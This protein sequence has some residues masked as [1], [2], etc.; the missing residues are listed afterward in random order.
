MLLK[1]DEIRKADKSWKTRSDSEKQ[2][3][4]VDTALMVSK[5]S[6]NNDYRKRQDKPWCVRIFGQTILN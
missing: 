1:F 2:D 3:Q 4:Y 6:I 5:K